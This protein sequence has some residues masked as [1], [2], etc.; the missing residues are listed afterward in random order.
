MELKQLKIE[1]KREQQRQE[2]ERKLKEEEAQRSERH[3]KKLT[4]MI[5]KHSLGK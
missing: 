1:R 3:I 2:H 5:G 4:T